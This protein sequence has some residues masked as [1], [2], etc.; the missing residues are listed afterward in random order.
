[1]KEVKYATQEYVTVMKSKWVADDGKEFDSRRACEDY[2][3]EKRIPELLNKIKHLDRT[4]LVP[5][6]GHSYNEDNRYY[7]LCPQKASGLTMINEV[8]CLVV[9]L[10]PIEWIGQWICVE[11]DEWDH[12]GYV[13]RLPD[14]IKHIV[15]F[16]T[17]FDLGFAIV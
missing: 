13:S 3:R 9:P 1:M 11:Y 12:C 17:E 15:E 16:L 7:W 6:D 4:D 8:F 2:E 14:S 5:L 10:A